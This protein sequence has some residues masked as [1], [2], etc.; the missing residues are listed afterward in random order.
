MK[1]ETVFLNGI[2]AISE[3]E[4]E[5]IIEKKREKLRVEIEKQVNDFLCRIAAIPKDK[6]V[7]ELKK[8]FG[9]DLCF[10]DEEVCLGIDRLCDV[11]VYRLMCKELC[12]AAELDLC[13]FGFK[14]LIAKEKCVFCN[15]YGT[16]EWDDY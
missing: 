4:L 5:A 3:H 10:T 7:F 2:G 16:A 11:I 1:Q 14:D 12:P 6:K 15:G 9:V 13:V 8:Q